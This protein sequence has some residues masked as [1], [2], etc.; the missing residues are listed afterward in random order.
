M[1]MARF[2]D[3]MDSFT[4]TAIYEKPYTTT[5]YYSM[6]LSR[7][8]TTSMWNVQVQIFRTTEKL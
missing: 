7:A 8:N 4:V 6:C 2:Y 1:I 3:V 5:E